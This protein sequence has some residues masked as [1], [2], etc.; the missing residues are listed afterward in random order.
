MFGLAP[1]CLGH[2]A[3]AR[4]D[5]LAP[6][7]PGISYAAA[8]T[9]PTAFLTAFAAL[10]PAGNGIPSAGSRALVHAGSGGL[11]LAAIQVAQLLGCRVLATAGSPAKRCTLRRLGVAATATSRSTEFCEELALATGGAGVHVA[12]NSLTSPGMVAASLACLAPGSRLVEVGKRGIWSAARVAQGT[13]AARSRGWLAPA[14]Q[15]L[16]ASPRLHCPHPLWCRA[17]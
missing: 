17:P 15:T 3:Y 13:R 10:Q 11:G 14:A 4:A 8:S 16:G 9:L 7:P 1:G 2:C 12:L 6:L 5:L